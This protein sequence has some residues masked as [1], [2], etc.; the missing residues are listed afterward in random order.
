MLPSA[1]SRATTTLIA[2]ARAG[3]EALN[4]TY[5]DDRPGIF[6]LFHRPRVW[7][8]HE[9]VWMGYERK[10]GKLEQFNALLLEARSGEAPPTGIV[11]G[12]A[13]SAFSD[14]VG[15]RSVLGS[16]RYVITLDTD[17]QLPRD[18]ASHAHRQHGSPA[19]SAACT[20]R[21]RAAWSRATRSCS[22]A[23]RSVSRAPAVLGSRV[24]SPAKRASIRT[25]ARS[26]TSIRISSARVR[27]SARAST[28][29]RRSRGPCSGR[30]P[31]NL[32]LSH[33]LL[34]GGY[35]RSA[36][37]TDVDLIEEH[38]ISYAMEASRRHRW[39]R[40]DWQLAG[41][42]LPR[43]PGPDGKRRPNP[44]SPLSVWKLFDNLRR[45]L[46]P[47]ALVALLLGGWLWGPG[48][49]WLWGLL[50]VGALFLP[51]LLTA[52]IELVRKPEEWGWPV[53]LA[54]T[55]KSAVRPLARA[56]LALV[57]LPYD[58]LV[59]L[60]AIL[61]SG[62]KMLFT[63]RGLLLWHLPSYGRRNARRTPQGFLLE[64]WIGP[65]LAVA[66]AV[67]LVFVPNTR[68]ADWPF[69]V[70]VLVLWLVS[71]IVGW[72]ISRPLRPS[73][74]SLSAQQQAFLRGLARRTWRYF[75]DFVGPEHN[76]LPP[77]NYQEYPSA[78]V[79]AR[80]SPTNMGMALLANL[81][82]HD[83]GYISTGEFLRRTDRALR[84]ME[85]LERFRG[86]F[87][88]WYDTRTLQPLHPQ[89]ISSVDS[90]NLA[91][92]LLA[93]RAGLSELK[94]RPVLGHRA[95]D[96]LEDTLL[97]LAAHVPSPSG[98]RGGEADQVLAETRF[99]RSMAIGE[100]PALPQALLEE[101]SISPPR[102]WWPRRPRRTRASSA[103]GHAR[104]IANAADFA[105][106]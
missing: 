91:G 17:T 30:F 4:D 11:R 69:V 72:W 93:L 56:L 101:L 74:A 97:A 46:V 84:T 89:Y 8:P 44:L 95:F 53:H 24:C 75:T 88:N 61:R 42:L 66:L 9:R 36:L 96:G 102:N 87:Y 35:A 100:T 67:V 103:T 99:S 85:K 21:R 45:S 64:M 68:L 20:T 12:G 27:S 48:P 47:A 92:S 98:S 19:Q 43:V 104:S 32:I 71:P 58:A 79:A 86:H 57:L 23:P 37:V 52:A 18:A 13:D 63:R 3:I 62:V 25:R 40:G 51:A 81:A 22:R 94:N 28:T 105:T 39:A 54:L 31:E 60:D 16:I 80:T 5:G 1:P 50:V 106:T 10:R 14:I 15:D 33:D 38:P 65:V 70:P 55:G 78:T 73:A 26:P 76:W 6:Y 77:D 7:N 34:E 2:L 59:Y 29:S 41:W 90:G 49:S 83:F 82:A